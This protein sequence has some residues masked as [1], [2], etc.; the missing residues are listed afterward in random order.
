MRQQY[1]LIQ[2]QPSEVQACLEGMRPCTYLLL[3]YSWQR[4]A[5]QKANQDPEPLGHR[6][7]ED[8]RILQPLS[9]KLP[10]TRLAWEEC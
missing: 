6:P 2:L 10:P 5:K 4:K 8:A 1:R 9:S 3:Y 7:V